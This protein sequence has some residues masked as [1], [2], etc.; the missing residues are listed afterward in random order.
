MSRLS[1]KARVTLW[2]TLLVALLAGVML[3]ALYA[4]VNRTT[5]AYYEELLLQAMASASGEVIYQSGMPWLNARGVAD[6]DMVTFVLLDEQGGLWSGRWPPFSAAL[7]DG[8]LRT[9]GADGGT[10]WLFQDLRLPL[11]QGDVWLRGYL[12]PDSMRFLSQTAGMWFAY[13]LPGLIALAA[14]GGWLITSRAFRPVARMAR[15]ADAIAGGGDLS[16]RFDTGKRRKP[17]E[18]GYLALTFNCMFE[19][20]EASFQRERRFTD[21]ASH[22]LRT[23]IAVIT[24]ACDYALSQNDPAEYREALETVRRKADDMG[25]MSSQLLMLARMDGGRV[26][27][28]TETVNLSALLQTVAA[29]L[30]AGSDKALDSNGVAETLCCSGDEL[31]LMRLLVN[32]MENAFRFAR[33][34]VVVSLKRE[35]ERLCM[36]VADDGP[37]IAP[38]DL[39]RVFE[40][41]YQADP[42][43]GGGAGLGLCTARSIARLH[44][45]DITAANAPGGGVR[46]MLTL[47]EKKD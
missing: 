29:E 3:W 17:D 21:D 18:I 24:S 8:T 27:L 20:L 31:M 7:E 30:A 35:G 26:T 23:P 47:P 34:R 44:G 6:F 38:D 19:R 14:L 12:R 11:A 13:L 10:A 5:R 2:Y 40:R 36:C 43:R 28:H 42:S 39:E 33:T 22:E 4:N 45:G 1:I 32:L 37:G 46:F 9:A 25:R 15:G 41:F 16:L